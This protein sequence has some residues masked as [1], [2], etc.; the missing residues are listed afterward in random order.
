MYEIIDLEDFTKKVEKCEMYQFSPVALEAI[1]Y[2]LEDT[3]DGDFQFYPTDICICYKE[4]K[5]L[6]SFYED[7]PQDK[8]P[9]QNIIFSSDT[10]IIVK[11]N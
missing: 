7:Y 6:E 11:I 9:C 10:C 1:F 8:A 5:T 3:F 2:Y 4:Y